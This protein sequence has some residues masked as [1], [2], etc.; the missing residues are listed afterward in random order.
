MIRNTILLNLWERFQKEKK[1]PKGSFIRVNQSDIQSLC[2]LLIQTLLK[3]PILLKLK[4]SLKIYGNFIDN[5]L[6]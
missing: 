2:Q 5:L 3:D 4:A 1:L 6:I